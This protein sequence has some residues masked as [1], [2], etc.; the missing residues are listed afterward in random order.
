[1]ISDKTVLKVLPLLLLMI[2]PCDLLQAAD[3][4]QIGDTLYTWAPSGLNVRAEASASSSKVGKL[5][6]GDRVVVLAKTDIPYSLTAIKSPKVYEDLYLE[7]RGQKPYQLNGYWV[8]VTGPGF[9]G[10]V[11]DMYLLAWQPPAPKTSFHTYF[12]KLQGEPI[13]MDTTWQHDASGN[14]NLDIY[15]YRGESSEGIVFSGSSGE[16]AVDDAIGIPGMTL[17]EGFVFCNFFMPLED[18]LR[19]KQGEEPLVLEQHTEENLSLSEDELCYFSIT[20]REGIL[21]IEWGCSC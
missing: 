17:E 12:E 5:Q 15:N 6:P 1:M 9:S 3:S 7:D 4:Y 16:G 2:G 13:L 14:R 19:K 20:I 21:R 10:Y 11:I 8:K 18:G